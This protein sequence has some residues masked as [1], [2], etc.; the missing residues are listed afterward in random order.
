MKNMQQ[1]EDRFDISSVERLK[2]DI[3]YAN[4]LLKEAEGEEIIV[5]VNAED[6]ENNYKCSLKE[7]QKLHVSYEE[8]KVHHIEKRTSNEITVLIPGQKRFQ[9]VK[10][11]LG[12]GEAVLEEGGLSC[13]MLDLQVGAG[14]VKLENVDVGSANIQCGAGKFF[15]R[16]KVHSNF[17]ADC[18]V[19]SMEVNLYGKEEDY[20]YKVSCALGKVEINHSSARKF[21]SQKSITNANAIGTVTLNCGLGKIE[22]NTIENTVDNGREKLGTEQRVVIEKTVR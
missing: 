17:N 15:M 3:G 1:R 4:L 14:K 6:I 21:I 7:N 8:H 10:L 20:N 22:V 9:K 18:G 5:R 13:E 19:G 11:E 2:L 12:A 16:G